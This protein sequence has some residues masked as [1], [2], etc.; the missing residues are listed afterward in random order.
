MGE[1]LKY[2]GVNSIGLSRNNFS[3]NHISLIK[4]AYKILYRSEYNI[5]Q[6]VSILNEDYSDDSNI[7]EIINFIAKSSRGII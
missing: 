3:S 7:N 2:S 6:A 5:S 1:P 4:K